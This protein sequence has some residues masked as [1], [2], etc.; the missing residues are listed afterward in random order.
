MAKTGADVIARCSA[1]SDSWASGVQVNGAASLRRRD[2]PLI[3]ELKEL[4]RNGVETFDACSNNTFMLHAALMWTTNDF[5][6]YGNLSRWTTKGKY[7]RYSCSVE[8]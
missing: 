7:A 4:W 5:P 8:I 3:E 1:S 2:V 6:I